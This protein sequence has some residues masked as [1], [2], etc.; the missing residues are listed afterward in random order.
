MTRKRYGKIAVI[1]FIAAA[2]SAFFLVD[3]GSYLSLD[4]LKARQGELSAFVEDRPAAAIGGFFLLYVAVTALSLPGAAIMTLA[5]GAIFGLLLGTLVV[6]FAS[7]IGA[8]PH[9]SRRATC[10]ASGFAID[11]ASASRRSTKESPGT[12]HSTF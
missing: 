6:S 2:I 8:S 4:Q 3:F 12:V 5:A 10:F 1:L 11:S 9:F 7:A